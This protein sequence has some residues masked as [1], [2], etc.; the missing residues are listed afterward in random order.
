MS[1]GFPTCAMKLEQVVS[2][3]GREPRNLL[4]RGFPMV[5]RLPMPCGILLLEGPEHPI[6]SEHSPSHWLIHLENLRS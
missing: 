1:L 2:F 3:R 4:V 6:Q 5:L